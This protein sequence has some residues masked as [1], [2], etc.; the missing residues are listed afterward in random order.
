MKFKIEDPTKNDPE[1][2][3][4]NWYKTRL[5]FLKKQTI[6]LCSELLVEL[7]VDNFS[8]AVELTYQHEDSLI[9]KIRLLNE[10]KNELINNE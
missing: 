3:I 9:S 10:I 8:K 2:V 5:S 1:I 7:R 4:N 6:D